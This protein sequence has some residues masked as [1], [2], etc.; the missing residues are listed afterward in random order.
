MRAGPMTWVM[1]ACP[2]SGALDRENTRLSP[3]PHLEDDDDEHDEEDDEALHASYSHRL[4]VEEDKTKLHTE[5]RL[6]GY[7]MMAYR[8]SAFASL[9]R[10]GERGER[11]NEGKRRTMSKIMQ[12]VMMIWLMMEFL[13]RSTFTALVT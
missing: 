1:E 11:E 4:R 9:L 3:P 8:S 7:M 13:F 2:F 10:L 6:Q 5:D 12:V